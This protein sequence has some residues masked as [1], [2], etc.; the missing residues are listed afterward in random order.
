M[1]TAPHACTQLSSLRRAAPLLTLQSLRQQLQGPARL[2][3]SKRKAHELF[4]APLSSGNSSSR[5]AGLTSGAG[6]AAPSQPPQLPPPCFP[7]QSSRGP[8]GREAAEAWARQQLAAPG[9]PPL[10]SLGWGGSSDAGQ[11][12]HGFPR[13]RAFE[14]LAELEVPLPRALWFL[15]VLA[16]N[17]TR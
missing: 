14:L 8:A 17:R 2:L 9:A 3:A 12:P 16:L 4:D 10:R 13:T 1:Q 15:R 5:G 7:Q 6:A 11:V